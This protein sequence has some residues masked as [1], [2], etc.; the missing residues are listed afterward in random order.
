MHTIMTS[1]S[2]T[3]M[4]ALSKVVVS[5]MISATRLGQMVLCGIG[6][7]E[8]GLATVGDLGIVFFA[9]VIDRVS[10]GFGVSSRDQGHRKWYETGP[11]G[12]IR[13]LCRKG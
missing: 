6:R 3:I 7:M 8:M 13:S 5:S 1:V 11:T 2:Q 12:G 9:I 10:R 4:M